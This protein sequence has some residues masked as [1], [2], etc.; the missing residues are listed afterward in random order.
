MPGSAGRLRV[1]RYVQLAKQIFRAAPVLHALCADGGRVRTGRGRDV[2]SPSRVVAVPA[3]SSLP[4]PTAVTLSF[5]HPQTRQWTRQSFRILLRNGV[6]ASRRIQSDLL[7][8]SRFCPHPCRVRDLYA[9]RRTGR[10]RTQRTYVLATV[11]FSRLPLFTRPLYVCHQHL[12]HLGMFLGI[13]CHHAAASAMRHG[14]ASDMSPLSRR[15]QILIAWPDHGVPSFSSRGCA[16]QHGTRSGRF[17]V[18]T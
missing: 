6:R 5:L 1:D 3:D 17:R 11:E 10:W 12:V 14:Q 9:G 18:R 13:H 4:L 8:M 15:V 2:L 7:Y 16:A